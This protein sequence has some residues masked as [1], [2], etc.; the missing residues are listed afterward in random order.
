MCVLYDFTYINSKKKATEMGIRSVHAWG[1]GLVAE[2]HE[3]TLGPLC[4]LWFPGV[5][6]ATSTKSY[7]SN[8]LPYLCQLIYLKKLLNSGREFAFFLKGPESK[9]PYFF[10]SKIQL[11]HMSSEL[12]MTI[13]I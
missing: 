5:P 7:T 13:G 2:G 11:S 12:K 10:C 8:I 9:F 6:M 1:S 4:V 3:E